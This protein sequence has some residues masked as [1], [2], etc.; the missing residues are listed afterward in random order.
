MTEP[1]EKE[2][3]EKDVTVQVDNTDVQSPRD[4]T[5]E[6]LLQAA[7]LD[8]AKREL[9]L[10]QGKKTTPFKDPNAELKLHPNEQFIT[11]AIGPTPVS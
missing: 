11:L 8:P 5:V 1:R 7:G 3:P 2:R 10:V 9:V 6:A 4:T